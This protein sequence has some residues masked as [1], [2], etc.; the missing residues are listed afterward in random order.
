MKGTESNNN[1][2]NLH[3]I[4]VR[5]KNE[6][7]SIT[8]LRLIGTRAI[9][10]W[11]VTIFMCNAFTPRPFKQTWI[12]PFKQTWWCDS[13]QILH[14]NYLT[15]TIRPVIFG[16]VI[17]LFLAETGGSKKMRFLIIFAKTTFNKIISLQLL[18][19]FS[20]PRCKSNVISWA[21]IERHRDILKP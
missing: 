8:K 2:L 4:W 1:A 16:L 18:N 12:M 20:S 15:I 3:F 14:G 21:F 10:N 19:H 17:I 6:I 9:Q 7:C 13:V 11:W 5:K